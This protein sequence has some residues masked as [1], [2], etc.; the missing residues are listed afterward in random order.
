MENHEI[1]YDVIQIFSYL[2]I[3]TLLVKPIGCYMEKVYQGKRN[4][5]SLILSPLENILYKI[6]CIDKEKEMDW[7]I[8]SFSMLIFNGLGIIIV[9]VILSLQSILP[10]NPEKF[11][12][13]SWHLAVNTA[14]SFITNTNWQAYS[15]ESAASYF[16]QTIALM[17]QHFLSAATGMAILIALIRGFTRNSAITLGNFWVDLIRS[18]LYILM[19]LSFIVSIFLVSQGVV[20][21]YKPYQK[22]ALIQPITTPDGKIIKEQ[23]LPMGPIASQEAI[24]ELGTNGG[25]WLNANSSHPFENPTP[26][27]NFIEC[28]LILL[29][30]G[31]LT[32]TFGRMV[33]NTRQGWAIY[34]AMMMLLIIAMIS[35][36]WAEYSGNPLMK[37]LGIHGLYMEGKEV[38]FGLGGTVIFSTVTTAASCGAVNAMHDSLTPIGGLIPML[39]ILSGEIV[40]GGVGSGL[41]TM[42]AFVIIAVFVAGLMIGRT[43][44]YLGKKIEANDMWM[45]IITIFTSSVLVLLFTA[46]ALI[47]KAGTDSILNPGPHGLS[48]VLYAIASA[49]NNNGSAFAGLNANIVFYN[50]ITA[51]AMLLGRFSPAV[52]IL[53]LA[54]SL[55]KKKYIQPSAGTLPTDQLPFVLWLIMVILFVGALTFFPSISMGPLV[56][57]MIMG[58]GF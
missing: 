32:Y 30:P 50:L 3:L 42:L 21:N 31:A 1:I 43:P 6:G 27:S 24:K 35:I 55:V 51:L 56:E 17:V 49:S 37:R 46:L 12:G 29:I 8:Y 16:S 52:A 41:Y 54:G 58:E 36:Y 4:F 28:L 44:E 23:R 25:G 19:P 2:I 10:L 53:A 47:T 34:A 14:V 48:E 11:T 39:L 26:L 15:G 20:Q 13:F 57:H 33:G 18:V 38:R 40:F 7:K 5:L 45:S 9:F 22:S